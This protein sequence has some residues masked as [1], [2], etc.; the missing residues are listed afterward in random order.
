MTKFPEF[1]TTV[2][3]LMTDYTPNRADWLRAIWGASNLEFSGPPPAFSASRQRVFWRLNQRRHAEVAEIA[4]RR[5]ELRALL[6]FP[7]FTNVIRQSIV[8]RPPSTNES[9]RNGNY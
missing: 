5:T 3:R 9:F 2:E 8:R 6:Q 4:Q 1:K 7:R